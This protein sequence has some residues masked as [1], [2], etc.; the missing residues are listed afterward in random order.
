MD[1]FAPFHL[2]TSI[3]IQT[4]YATNGA[5]AGL[6]LYDDEV[7]FKPAGQTIQASIAQVGLQAVLDLI[8]LKPGV[9]ALVLAGLVPS[10]GIA[11]A[12]FLAPDSDVSSD[13]AWEPTS[14]TTR[15]SMIDEF[16]SS[17]DDSVATA[18]SSER[19]FVV[20]L[21][22]ATDPVSNA[23]HYVRYRLRGGGSSIT[24]TLLQTSTVI[25]SW[26][27][28][29]PPNAMTT[30]RQLLSGAEADS[31]SDYTALRLSF[32]ATP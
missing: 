32:K 16:P 26:V 6:D 25:A 8:G 4:A 2:N 30:F 20:S 28:S 9:A 27:H 24:V 23:N 21:A 12:Q 3:G 1:A 22:D 13:G 5:G 14:G 7:H 10:V 11:G 19:T 17:D 31:I 29:P 15:Y 18:L